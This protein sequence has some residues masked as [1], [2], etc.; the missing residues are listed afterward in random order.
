MA[1]AVAGISEDDPGAGISQVY[2]HKMSKFGAP[3]VSS[4]RKQFFSKRVC[5]IPAFQDCDRPSI[6]IKTFGAWHSTAMIRLI[7]VAAFCGPWPATYSSQSLPERV[8][9]TAE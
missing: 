3:S 5:C 7:L 2:F 1:V 6:L 9:A 8:T 4:K